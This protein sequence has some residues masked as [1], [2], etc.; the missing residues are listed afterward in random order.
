MNNW[1]KL[2][3]LSLS[4]LTLAACGS[5]ESTEEAAASSS[6][7]ASESVLVEESSSVTA[8]PTKSD[9]I[10]EGS[11]GTYEITAVEQMAGEHGD[12]TRI[13]AI[14]MNYTNTTD[15]PQNPWFAIAFDMTAT[16]E[17]DVTIETLMGANGQYPE[18]YKPEAV[19]MG[20]T[21][22]KPGATVE[23]VV[24]YTLLF[25]GSPVYLRDSNMA[26][27]DGTLFER[28]IETSAE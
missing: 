4:A 7:A 14:T 16:Q 11:N 19:A 25:P 1:K 3:L 17:T 15:E 24:G 28:V 9:T 10:F 23:A 5:A 20:E 18:G 27:D 22:I 21:D 6:S 8:E 12:N 2:A 13:I 26:S